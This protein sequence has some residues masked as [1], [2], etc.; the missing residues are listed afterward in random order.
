MRSWLDPSSLCYSTNPSITSHGNLHLALQALYSHAQSN[1]KTLLALILHHID[2]PISCT[3]LH[4]LAYLFI[5]TKVGL[6]MGRIHGP[7][8]LSHYIVPKPKKGPKRGLTF[9]IST[10]LCTLSLL[11]CQSPPKWSSMTKCSSKL[12]QGPT[13]S[14]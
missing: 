6:N 13:L 7:T 1:Y 9:S 10:S 8:S 5:H 4:C 11:G 14:K 3:F 12:G 2:A